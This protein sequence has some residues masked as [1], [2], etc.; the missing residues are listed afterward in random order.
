MM[1]Y[2]EVN[3]MP[4]E[5]L[6]LTSDESVITVEDIIN[7]IMTSPENTNANILREMLN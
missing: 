4:K 3:D 5:I 7:Y 6:S 2:M 1:K